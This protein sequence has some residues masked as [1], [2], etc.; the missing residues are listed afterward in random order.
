MEIINEITIGEIVKYLEKNGYDDA[1]EMSLEDITE[2][3]K[4]AKQF[5]EAV[6]NNYHIADYDRW[7]HLI[8]VLGEEISYGTSIEIGR[9]LLDNESIE[10]LDL[11]L[12][13]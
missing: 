3:G 5:N 6:S 9:V 12:F 11:K 7:V 8:K 1:L 2:N 13:S 10:I 4:F